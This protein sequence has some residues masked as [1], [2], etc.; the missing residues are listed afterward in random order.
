MDCKK[1]NCIYVTADY[2]I[3]SGSF[4]TE[5][6]TE[7]QLNQTLMAAIFYTSNVLGNVIGIDTFIKIMK[8]H[9]I[10]VL[11]DAVQTVPICIW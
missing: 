7:I 4:N 9:N 3:K 10:N 2:D 5:T 6:L 11:F 1:R 8:Q